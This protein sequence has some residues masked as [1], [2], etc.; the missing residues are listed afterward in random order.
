MTHGF[1]SASCHWVTIF[2][3]LMKHF[4]IVLFDNLSFGSNPRTGVCNIN[5]LDVEQVD[6]W[7]AEYWH[8]WMTECDELP[9]KF[10]LAGH[11]FGG[12]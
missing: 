7:L 2:G 4:R 3:E 5:R 11:S 1:G 10:L 6:A 12:Y 8:Q 9:P